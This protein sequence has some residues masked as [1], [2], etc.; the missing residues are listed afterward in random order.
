MLSGGIEIDPLI[1]HSPPPIFSGGPPNNG[2]YVKPPFF[3]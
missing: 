1:T 3:Q 2:K